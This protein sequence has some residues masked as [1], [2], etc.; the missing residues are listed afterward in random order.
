MKEKTM[1]PDYEKLYN[2][3][4][5][6]NEEFK[7]REMLEKKERERAMYNKIN[8]IYDMLVDKKFDEQIKE[9]LK[10]IEEIENTMKREQKE[11]QSIYQD[12]NCLNDIRSEEKRMFNY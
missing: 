10:K 3:E 5:K 8:M 6:A 4:I 2:E 11:I 9:N 12:I 1:K 7:M